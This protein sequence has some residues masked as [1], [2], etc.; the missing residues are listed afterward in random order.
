MQVHEQRATLGIENVAMRIARTGR[1][2]LPRGSRHAD[3]STP[4]S[5]SR[6]R[7]KSSAL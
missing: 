5:S 4:S 7:S 2:H 6:S 3:R 1:A